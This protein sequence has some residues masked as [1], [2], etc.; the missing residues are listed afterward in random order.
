MVIKEIEYRDVLSEQE[1]KTPTP[2][3]LAKGRAGERF[4][5][6]QQKLTTLS[7]SK[8]IAILAEEIPVEVEGEETIQVF[9]FETA[10]YRRGRKYVSQSS[11]YEV[12]P[13]HLERQFIMMKEHG[14]M[15]DLAIV[16][17]DSSFT[18][19]ERFVTSSGLVIR[20]V[21][22]VYNEGSITEKKP[23]EIPNN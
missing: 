13:D 6:I 21:V 22:P 3:Q 9:Y 7:E 10:F 1:V 14:R 23:K 19:L 18:E 12:T 5:E 4:G 11:P 16:A 17:D 2:F 20:G 8:V 15:V